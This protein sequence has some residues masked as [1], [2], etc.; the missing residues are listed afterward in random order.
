MAI[1][2]QNNENKFKK[3]YNLINLPEIK[4]NLSKKMRM[5]LLIKINTSK[6]L[7]TIIG[8]RAK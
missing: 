5:I 6:S 4:I 3:F 1:K 8:K 2:K 7:L